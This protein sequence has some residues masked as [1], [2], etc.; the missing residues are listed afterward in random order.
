MHKN[1]RRDL[2]VNIK[3]E[4]KVTGD[5]FI[6]G[7][8]IQGVKTTSWGTS[9]LIEDDA[10]Q[11]LLRFKRRCLDLEKSTSHIMNMIKSGSKAEDGSLKEAREEI[12]ALRQELELLKAQPSVEEFKRELRQRSAETR[13]ATRRKAFAVTLALS[14]QGLGTTEI[15]V[16]LKERGFGSSTANIARAL[17]VSKDGDKERI[18]G[19]FRAFPEEFSGFTEQ[20]LEAWYTERHERLQRIAEVRSNRKA[21]S[22][23]WGE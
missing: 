2:A 20:D 3:S 9:Y 1:E 14:L 22:S 15:A 8:Q 6:E 13:G 5:L 16:V 19:I 12:K 17:S 11:E 23:E 10:L 21:K 18:W 4:F 7:N